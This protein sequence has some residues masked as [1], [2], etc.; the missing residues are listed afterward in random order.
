MDTKNKNNSELINGRKVV[1]KHVAAIH[2][3]NK[4]SLL[5]RKISNALLYNAFP[6]LNE[7]TTHEITI[8]QLKRLLGL[9]TRNHKILK[10][11]LKTLISTVLE[12]NLLGDEANDLEG[13]N[14]SSV[15]A[16]V[17]I[18]N[19]VIMYQYSE[20]IKNL[21]SNPSIYGKINLV[22]QSRFKSAYALALYENC[23][24]FRG[25]KYTKNFDINLL[26]SLLGVG[27]GEYLKFYDFNRRVLSVAVD[28]INTCSDIRVTAIPTTRGK[29]IVAIKFA[30]EERNIMKRF[31]VTQS[32]QEDTVDGSVLNETK[33]VVQYHN[34]DL[35]R[36]L[37]QTYGFSKSQISTV[38]DLYEENYI[39]EKVY[40]IESSQSF[41]NGNIK[42]LAKYLQKA[43]AEDYQVPKSSKGAMEKICE[44]NEQSKQ[45][46]EVYNQNMSKYLCYQRKQI[47]EAFDRASK[48][49]KDSIFKGFDKYIAKSTYGDL[50]AKDGIDNPVIKD[51]FLDYIL[52]SHKSLLDSIQSFDEYCETSLKQ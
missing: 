37:C 4:L 15:L 24:R 47:P 22:I 36:K 6:C 21:L 7:K 27:E 29:R 44:I 34:D 2:C 8:E 50:Y 51:I 5:E 16:A 32:S 46:K 42:N 28:E 11:A 33:E 25:L 10:T 18:E 3:S 14:A 30:L 13:W 19:G 48:E 1:N 12:W 26:R 43:L 39:S 49:E 23:T 52:D 40:L 9:N 45:V 41:K 35:Q 17:Q 38:F 20:I 31:R